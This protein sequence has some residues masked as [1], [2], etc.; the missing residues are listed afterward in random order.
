[1]CSGWHSGQAP[2]HASPLQT[3]SRFLHKE[4][5]PCQLMSPAAEADSSSSREKWD[6]TM[7]RLLLLRD[8]RW[9]ESQRALLS[10]GVGRSL[11]SPFQVNLPGVSSV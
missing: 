3:A 6:G 11:K 10:P 5:V 7:P 9:I 8:F 4:G 2:L 1:M